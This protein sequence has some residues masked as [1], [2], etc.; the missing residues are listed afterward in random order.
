MRFRSDLGSALSRGGRRYSAN[1]SV[2]TL[3]YTSGALKTQKGVTP[4]QLKEWLGFARL[5]TTQIY[6]HLGKQPKARKVMEAT[7][8]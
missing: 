3:R 7:S 5:D 4:W 8:L 2:H 1:A 6:V